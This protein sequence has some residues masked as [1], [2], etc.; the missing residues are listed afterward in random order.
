ML[1]AAGFGTR[2]GTLT[3]ERPKPLIEVGGQT[4]LDHALALTDGQGIVRRVVNAH[5]LAPQIEAH[6][7]G[8]PGV[9]VVT[10][11]PDILET[12][13]GLRN[14]LPQLGSGAVFTLNSD[15]I[16]AGP[17]PLTTLRAA[18]DPV[19][20]GALLLLIEKSTSSAHRGEGDFAM[21]G[22]GRLSRCGP[23][24]YTGAQIIDPTPLSAIP[25]KVFSLN[26]V[27]DQLAAE[28]RL[29]GIRHLGDWVDV[30]T[31]A[32]IEAAEVLLSGSGNVRL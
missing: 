23:M 19:R 5:Y 27:W 8:R 26:R 15:A 17:N 22:S 25:D 18:W 14:A 24:V 28:G 21:D 29:Y 10:E 4:L 9:T 7:A 6:L 1:F 30:G 16:W 3:A 31:L 32:G 13:G 20:M 11:A 2:M 12:G